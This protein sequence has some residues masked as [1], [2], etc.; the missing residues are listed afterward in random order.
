MTQINRMR[1]VNVAF[2]GNRSHFK[3]FRLSY[4]GKSGTY[5]LYN[6]GGKSVLLLMLL[7]PTR[8]GSTLDKEQPLRNI[9]I[10]TGSN[11]T[12]HSLIEWVLDEGSA[13]KYLLT[14]FCIR[15]T[16]D[17]SGN[18]A[19]HEDPSS[20]IVGVDYFN[21]Y[22]LYNNPNEFDINNIELVRE[23]ENKTT[24]I[25]FD[26]LRDLLEEKQKTKNIDIYP[27]RK[28][29]DYKRFL[30]HY[31]IYEAEWKMIM[32]LNQDENFVA[33]YFRS[34]NTS[35]K[36][37]ENLLIMF[38]E[39][40][41]HNTLQNVRDSQTSGMLLAKG[42]IEIR[43]NLERLHKDKLQIN[44]FKKIR[45]YYEQVKDLTKTLSQDFADY[46]ALQKQ[47][48]MVAN[49]INSVIDELEL[50]ASLIGLDISETDQKLQALY[51]KKDC[52]EVQAK[53]LAKEKVDFEIS[54][55]LDVIEDFKRKI[56]DA[57]QKINESMAQ[58]SYCDYKDVE[59]DIAVAETDLEN[60][61]KSGEEIDQEW[62]SAGYNYKREVEKQ[63]QAFSLNL[64]DENHQLSS[65]LKKEKGLR[66][67]KGGLA[68]S[69][70]KIS[71]DIENKESQLEDINKELAKI[72]AFLNESGRISQLLQP[73]EGIRKLSGEITDCQF[74]LTTAADNIS[75]FNLELEKIKDLLTESKHQVAMIDLEIV[76]FQKKFDE[77]IQKTS[78][79]QGIALTHSFKGEPPDLQP[80][81]ERN[82]AELE[83]RKYDLKAQI[84]ITAQKQHLL[85]EKGY[86]VP[87]QEVIRLQEYVK[88]KLGDA[89]LGAEWLSDVEDKEELLQQ[90][91]LLP[92]SV[93][94]TNK[95]FEKLKTNLATYGERFGDYAIPI[96]NLDAV[97]KGQ[98]SPNGN[99]IFS[100][101]RTELYTDKSKFTAY[102][103]SLAQ[104]Q[105]K[106]EQ[107][108]KT[109]VGDISILKASL[110]FLETYIPLLNQKEELETILTAKEEEKERVE[111]SIK[112]NSWRMKDQER[113]LGREQ[114]TEKKL[115][116]DLDHLLKVIRRLETYQEKDEQASL[117]QK[118]I[119]SLRDRLSDINQDIEWK[120][121]EINEIA[122]KIETSRQALQ[123]I[124]LQWTLSS[125]EQKSLAHFE[126]GIFL[127]YGYEQAKSRFES[128][129]ARK[130]GM[131]QQRETIEKKLKI[132][133]GRK[134]NFED[135]LRNFGFEA[136]YFR[137]LED[138]GHPVKR[139]S[140]ES[141]ALLKKQKDD[142]NRELKKQDKSQKELEKKSIALETSINE[143]MER[144]YA[145]YRR[146]FEPDESLGLEEEID[147][148]IKET[149]N[150]I[151][152]N[153]IRKKECVT[154]QNLA[155][156]KKN[157]HQQEFFKFSVPIREFGIVTD[158]IAS[159]ILD[160]EELNGQYIGNKDRIKRHGDL[161]ITKIKIFIEDAKNMSVQY[162]EPLQK[163]RFPGKLSE[164]EKQLE[165][166]DYCVGII[167]DKISEIDEEIS[168]LKGYKENHVNLCLQRAEEIILELK[169]INTLPAI[170]IN[171][172]L[173]NM[174]KIEFKDFSEED[175]RG[176]MGEYITTLAQQEFEIKALSQKLAAKYLVDRITDLDRA[177][178]KLFKVEAD[179][180]ESRYLEWKNAVGST[181]Q[182]SSLYIVF[183]I[184]LISFIR[185]IGNQAD[186]G[187]S[188][189]VLFLDNPFATFASPYLW[190][191]IFKIL[192]ENN[193]Q[194]IA[195]AHQIN[196]RI[197]SGFDI[198]Y[199][200]GEE[201]AANRKKI[202]VKEVK[203]EVDM[204]QMDFER[205]NYVQE[206][207]Y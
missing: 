53:G 149:Q 200:L 136:G 191:P 167:S 114:R 169:K 159:E 46:E 23:A 63:I 13:Y 184:S 37:I 101:G 81:L 164:S 16:K 166:I 116:A 112:E 93:L 51:Y 48:V 139:I 10:N 33:R 45:G 148:K 5:D 28:T 97:R 70:A 190:D 202:I 98:V 65:L 133:R 26:S 176:R 39:N 155:I 79:Y 134:E 144:I 125:L 129:N 6:G 187:K 25:G 162:A 161:L 91:P 143:K 17:T 38:I 29:K 76:P 42:L 78:A 24:Y 137:G 193:V 62:N 188:S 60:L 179:S 110:K 100:S 185:L 186:F 1:V 174:V 138:A 73:S 175:K 195:F 156:E 44:D 9:F 151:D 181:G 157:R 145:S 172:Q 71:S 41:E 124:H 119:K 69:R 3:D 50:E 80:L 205:L 141:M 64:E 54:L 15:A 22:H 75:D 107:E 83:S 142:L 121:H 52:L 8:P 120:D 72:T 170:Q 57:E 55:L 2:N 59:S 160:F 47:F 135:T 109:I 158:E 183:L 197:V 89:F 127:D 102:T 163:F 189:K 168:T 90:N 126:S 4:F 84:E 12:S 108:L 207:F 66:D 203:T 177:K 74:A 58:N 115:E 99:M 152:G 40:M 67:E 192:K 150:A 35:R 49:K 206:T 199:I 30:R 132:C 14:G 104:E 153:E 140:N 82:K 85:A 92:Y 113:L 32:D 194:L 11:H 198:N 146:A 201:I 117:L 43:E 7:Q 173:E 31:G 111:A 118:D 86:Y 27:M 154:K 36:L 87:N 122:A 20:D 96:Q 165:E 95:V 18:S 94:V 204:Q 68:E 56:E 147:L 180:E 103:H 123:D 178:V 61:T 128:L 105:A 106:L 130:S 19:D 21:Y 88:A 196:S 182:K 171:G 77:I 131:V 34:N